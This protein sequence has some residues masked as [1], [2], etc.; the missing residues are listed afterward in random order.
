MKVRIAVAPPG[1]DWSSESY[2]ALVDGLE[3]RGYDTIWLSDVPLS[4]AIDPIV[5]LSIAAGRTSRLK[6]GANVVPLGRNPL[7]LA[8][9]LAQIDQLSLGRLL[10]MMVPGIGLPPEREALGVTNLNRGKV[11]EEMVGLLREF[12]TGTPVS[13]RSERF[14]FTGVT[15]RPTPVQQPL[16]MWLGG[17]GPKA[18][19]RAG[20]ISDGWLGAALTPEEAGNARKVIEHAASEAGR[21]IDPEHFGLSLGYCRDE[22]SADALAFVASRRPDLSPLELLPSGKEGLRQHLSRLVDQGLSKFVLRPSGPVTSVGDELD[23]LADAVLD[24]QT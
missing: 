12:W 22:P 11:L 20:R 3:A 2:L 16:E 5:G 21:T 8:R 15:A 17:M 23:W 4:A 7:V 24:L 14:N 1:R 9:E 6:L 18:L 10:L 13:H 19:E